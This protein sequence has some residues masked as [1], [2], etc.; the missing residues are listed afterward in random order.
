MERWRLQSVI[1][2]RDEIGP[3][4]LTCII[5]GRKK[6][7]GFAV[8]NSREQ[9]LPL[10]TRIELRGDADERGASGTLEGIE[11]TFEEGEVLGKDGG[12]GGQEGIREEGVLHGRQARQGGG[13]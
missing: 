5:V 13:S 11:E 6:D 2:I 4:A 7:V 3:R 12:H 10:A 8:C 9:R 1:N